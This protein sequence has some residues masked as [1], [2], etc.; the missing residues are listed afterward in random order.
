MHVPRTDHLT[1]HAA[2]HAWH[3]NTGFLVHRG[4][5]TAPWPRLR[6]ARRGHSSPPAGHCGMSPPPGSGGMVVRYTPI[7]IAS[8]A[9]IPPRPPA[10]PDGIGRH[11]AELPGVDPVWMASATQAGGHP[12]IPDG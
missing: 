10:G 12:P 11:R 8:P 9:S 5:A 1:A 7:S 2:L 3:G 4:P 6:I